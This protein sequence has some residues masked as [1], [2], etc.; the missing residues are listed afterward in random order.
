MVPN[1]GI[2]PCAQHERSTH[3]A[4]DDGKTIMFLPCGTISFNANDVRKRYCALCHRF[5]NST[6]NINGPADARAAR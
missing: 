3:I 6:F 2:K 1:R 5:I 4:S